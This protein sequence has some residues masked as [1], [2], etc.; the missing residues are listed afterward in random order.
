MKT[1]HGA[2]FNRLLEVFQEC[3]RSGEE[4]RLFLETRNGLIFANLS[5]KLPVPRPGNSST[6]RQA[7]KKT[8]ST[9]RRDQERMAK[10]L[11]RKNST[12]SATSTPNQNVENPKPADSISWETPDQDSGAREEEVETTLETAAKTEP[13]LTEE[14]WKIMERL[15]DTKMRRFD[16]SDNVEKVTNVPFEKSKNDDGDSDDNDNLEAAKQWTMKQKLSF[17][18]LFIYSSFMSWLN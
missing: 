2:T 1:V 16:N 4:A 18:N 5:V 17:R 12:F 10:F 7:K 15:M 3:T 11:Q 14:D 13:G 8:P 6:F 9:L